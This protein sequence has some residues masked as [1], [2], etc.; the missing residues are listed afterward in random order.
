MQCVD[1]RRFSSTKGYCS[2]GKYYFALTATLLCMGSGSSG[3]QDG[4]GWGTGEE[5]WAC[6]EL[7][8]AS[9]W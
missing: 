9:I 5:L 3:L 6:C 7:R 8:R 1:H 4:K 2:W